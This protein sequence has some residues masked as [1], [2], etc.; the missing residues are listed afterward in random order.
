MPPDT[1]ALRRPLLKNNSLWRLRPYLRP[2]VVRLVLIWLAAMVGIGASIALP[3]VGEQVVDGP[4]RDG[5][6]GA[7]LLLGSIALGLGVLEALLIFLRRWSQ[8]KPVL[9]LETAI[10]DDVYAHLQR[11]PMSFHGDWQSG[12]MLSRITTD[13]STIRRFTGFGML[14]LVMN[15]LQLIVVT[16]LLLSKHWPLGLLV[17]ASAVPIVMLSM[18]FEKR[19][20]KISRQVQDEQGDLGTFVEESAIGIRT[21]KAFGRR[22]HVYESFDK[23]AVKVYDTSM[24]KVRLSARFF[25]FLEVIPNFTLALVLLVGALAVGQGQLTLGALF[26][27]TTLV[28]QLVWP[29]ASLG[30]ILAMAQEA[31]TSA[32]R[33]ME[34]MDMVPAITGGTGRIERPR[35][36]LR[37]EGVGFRFP[38]A[39]RPVLHDVWLEVRPGETVA[40]VGATGAGKTTLTALVPRLI[41]PTA[42]RVTIDGHDVRD[43]ALPELRSVV[44]TAFEEP[45][46]FS[47]SVRENLTLGR[48]DTTE[49]ELAGAIRTAQAMFVYDLP[50]GLDTRIGEQGL[51]L[52]GGQRQRLALARAVLSKPKIL[53]LDDTLSALDVETEALVEKALREVLREATGIVVAHRASTVLLADRVALLAD[54]AITHVGRHQDLLNEVPAYRALL[55]QDAD[56]DPSEGALR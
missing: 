41:D 55:A 36:H 11:L 51:S 54:G 29:I 14:F 22:R 31:M 50:W 35:G 18:R 23:A 24:D 4:V 33:V 5:D 45:T 27:F 15:I 43:L 47:M 34:V 46:L 6:G 2:Y 44:A 20:I 25:T 48:Q 17:A 38:G 13:L 42:G 40:V 49:E 26:A 30:Y 32:D 16:A 1:R 53:V 52:S 7:L 12:Q 21:I 9:G 37:F 3:L 10:R 19:Y 8:I 28:L 39:D 56:L